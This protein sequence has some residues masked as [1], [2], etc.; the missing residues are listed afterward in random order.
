M[1]GN[2]TCGEREGGRPRGRQELKYKALSKSS[3]RDILITSNDWE[4][5]TKDRIMPRASPHKIAALC[6][7]ATTARYEDKRRKRKDF[8]PS[9]TNT[10]C[11]QCGLLCKSI[12]IIRREEM[13]RKTVVRKIGN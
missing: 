5:L 9:N 3:F 2:R 10:G 7:E 1:P 12:G 11:Y 6:E 8:D 13:F 4:E